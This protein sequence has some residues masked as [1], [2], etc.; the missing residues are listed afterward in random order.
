MSTSKKLRDAYLNDLPCL[1]KLSTYCYTTINVCNHLLNV[2]TGNT[3]FLTF[4]IIYNVQ[5]TWSHSF[6]DLHKRRTS[7]ISLRNGWRLG[8]HSQ[9][10]FTY[11][12]EPFRRQ[13]SLWSIVGAIKFAYGLWNGPLFGRQLN[14]VS[15]RTYPK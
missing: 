3:G 7:F 15:Y 4:A 8:S 11:T 14:W 12:K 1:K 9:L 5:G 10:R 2:I 13:H 6:T